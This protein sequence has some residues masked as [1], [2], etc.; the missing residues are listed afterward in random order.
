MDGV[1]PLGDC[2]RWAYHYV[3]KHPNA[4]LYQGTVTAP[5]K[6]AGKAPYE[7]AWVLDGGVVKDWQTMVAGMG[8]RYRGVGWPEDVWARAWK[9]RH[10]KTFTQ[11]Q[12]HIAVVRHGHFGP[13][14]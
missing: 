4:V 8:G 14:P 13:W 10:V 1:K 3:H 12:A 7:H 11:E 6:D 9:P 5:Y 2:Y